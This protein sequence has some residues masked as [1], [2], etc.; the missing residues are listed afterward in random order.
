MIDQD[1]DVCVC[2]YHDPY[3]LLPKAGRGASPRRAGQQARLEAL[4]VRRKA[5]VDDDDGQDDGWL[6]RMKEAIYLKEKDSFPF[7]K[8]G[9]GIRE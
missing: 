7:K 2:P 9:H 1:D 5:V 6:S 4:F 3:L 8:D